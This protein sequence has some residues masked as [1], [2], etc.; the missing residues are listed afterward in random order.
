MKLELKQNIGMSVH[1][2]VVVTTKKGNAIKLLNRKM[3]IE[4]EVKEME[5]KIELKKTKY[6]YECL[7]C[8]YQH[9]RKINKIKLLN[10]KLVIE[11]EVMENEIKNEIKVKTKYCVDIPVV[12]K[13]Q[14]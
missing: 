10:G 13:A 7:H 11:N 2:A 14:K 4:N 6:W 5:L 12:D 1:I 9:K 8:S 3:Q